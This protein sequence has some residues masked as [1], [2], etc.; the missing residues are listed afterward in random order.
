MSN[1]A[2]TA[3]HCEHLISLIC[4]RSHFKAAH[5]I[6][7]D[8]LS[9]TLTDNVNLAIRKRKSLDFDMLLGVIKVIS[10]KFLVVVTQ[11]T[12]VATLDSSP[13]YRIDRL[14]FLPSN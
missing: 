8:R 7:I 2:Y 3:F 9:M 6:H 10:F 11:A 13:I 14:E 12:E 4:N 5:E 1:K